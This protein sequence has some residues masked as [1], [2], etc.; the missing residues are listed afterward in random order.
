MDLGNKLIELRKSKNLSQEEVAD[1]LGVTRQTVSKWETNQSTPDFDKIVPLCELYGI[2]PNELVIGK[3]EEPTTEQKEEIQEDESKKQKRTIG[4]ISG[5]ITYFI[6]VAWMVAGV[7]A[8]NINPVLVTAIFLII[9]GIGTCIIIY[10]NIMYKEKKKE[11][12]ELTAQKR[13]NN[14]L[15]I[16]T[17][18]IY[19]GVSFL[20]MAWHLT[21]I[22]WIIYALIYE[23]VSLIITLRGEK[24]EK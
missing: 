20:T 24:N 9:I 13:I 17:L 18:I 23:I 16:I 22:I 10:S 11:K 15:E 2:S 3:K 14:I 12:E 5:I 8:L 7:A 1:K 6:A 4:L 19:L 21:W